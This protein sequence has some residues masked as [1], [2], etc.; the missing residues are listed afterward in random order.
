VIYGL[1]AGNVAGGI[2]DPEKD[3]MGQRQTDDE[4][5]RFSHEEHYDVYRSGKNLRQMQRYFHL[6]SLRLQ[7][8]KPQ[9]LQ[10][11]ISIKTIGSR[12]SFSG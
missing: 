7:Q 11:G 4:N 8:G 6:Q 9:V 10:P 2:P 12:M 5:P 1:Y 3:R